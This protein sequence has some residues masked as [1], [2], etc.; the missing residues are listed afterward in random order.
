MIGSA[1]LPLRRFAAALTLLGLLAAGGSDAVAH[2]TAGLHPQR[3]GAQ[4]ELTSGC[5]RQHAPSF[6]LRLGSRDTECPA[7][8]LQVQQ[9]AAAPG[10]T[11]RP[12][13]IVMAAA[14]AAWEP[15]R[16]LDR[17]YR[18]AAPRGPPLEG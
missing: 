3:M 7:C 15:A 11:S 13:A 1:T 8:L 17:S 18:H 5:S 4:E 10:A 16:R 14:V 2:A 12:A 9:R 6:E